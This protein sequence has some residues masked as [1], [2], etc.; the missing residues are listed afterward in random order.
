MEFI[1]HAGNNN[2][3]FNTVLSLPLSVS[4]TSVRS[5]PSVGDSGWDGILLATILSESEARLVGGLFRTW[6]PLIAIYALKPGLP[7]K[8]KSSWLR[9]AAGAEDD[10]EENDEYSVILSDRAHS[11]FGGVTLAR[12]PI[13]YLTRSAEGVTRGSIMTACWIDRPLQTALD[14]TF[15]G[16]SHSAFEDI[17]S[18]DDSRDSRIGYAQR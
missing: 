7:R 11:Y 8:T 2:H 13:A 6:R 14:D 10:H 5:L 12:W 9:V 3:F 4:A 16:D 18:G 15:G 17:P 1:V